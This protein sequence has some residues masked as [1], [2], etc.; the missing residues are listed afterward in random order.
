[1]SSTSTELPERGKTVCETCANCWQ[2]TEASNATWA[3]RSDTDWSG[4]RHCGYRSRTAA[5]VKMFSAADQSAVAR[6]DRE[7]EWF[8]SDGKVKL[9]P[10]TAHPSCSSSTDPPPPPPGPGFPETLPV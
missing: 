6:F 10:A 5:V 1:M 9:S 8:N 4:L 3:L 2:L 7:V